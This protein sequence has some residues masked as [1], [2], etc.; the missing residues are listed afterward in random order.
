MYREK[1]KKIADK[2]DSIVDKLSFPR[3]L[4]GLAA[5]IIGLMQVFYYISTFDYYSQYVKIYEWIIPSA[6]I[7]IGGVLSFF[8]RTRRLGV[9]CAG[10][11]AFALSLVIIFGRV[12]KSDALFPIIVIAV[13]FVCAFLD[14]QKDHTESI[15]LELF[16]KQLKK[17]E[18]VIRMLENSKKLLGDDNELLRKN[19]EILEREYN[20]IKDG[21]KEENRKYAN[22][23][24]MQ[25]KIDLLEKEKAL[26]KNE[27]DLLNLKIDKEGKKN[28]AFD[29]LKADYDEIITRKNTSSDMMQVKIDMLEKEKT[30]LK[31]EI[32]VLN[33]EIGKEKKSIAYDALKADYDEILKNQRTL[34]SYRQDMAQMQDKVHKLEREKSWLES[35]NKK[36]DQDNSLLVDTV[37]DIQLINAFLISASRCLDKK[38]PMYYHTRY[39]RGY[40]ELLALMKKEG[41]FLALQFNIGLYHSQDWEK[42]KKQYEN[43][44]KQDPLAME[45]SRS[46]HWI[47]LGG[48]MD[49]DMPFNHYWDFWSCE[50]YDPESFISNSYPDCMRATPIKLGVTLPD[51]DRYLSTF[52]STRIEKSPYHPDVYIVCL[53]QSGDVSVVSVCLADCKKY[54]AYKKRVLEKR[55]AKRTIE[56]PGTV[57]DVEAI[58]PPLASV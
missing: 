52:L 44:K 31:N 9:L 41:L 17:T 24:L 55:R 25:I 51:F 54:I 29:A 8:N 5:I 10:C 50:K 28:I 43:L 36:L 14:D 35:D 11:G 33:L 6:I 21:L 15:D 16:N 49:S 57:D 37:R 46:C 22:F 4:I 30:L 19:I 45:I 34:D 7:P 3:D 42:R 12:D 20:R 38:K 56:Q 2:I 27:I 26:L 58:L 13:C 53:D 23:D 1:R 39:K 47:T 32:D 48:G 40:N 18:E